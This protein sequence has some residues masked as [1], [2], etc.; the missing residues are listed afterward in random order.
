MGYS[1]DFRKR[2]LAYKDKHSLTF[3]QTCTHFEVSMRTLFRWSHKIEPCVT[4][5]KPPT[6]ISDEALLTDVKNYPDDY[7]W[8]RAKRLGVAQSAIHYALKRLKITVKKN[9]KTPQR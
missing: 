9:A 7:Q 3:E 1:L 4:R 5:N 6:K 8:E 2:V